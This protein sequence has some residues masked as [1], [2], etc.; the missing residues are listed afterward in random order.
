VA[1][2]GWLIAGDLTDVTHRQIVRWVAIEDLT[3][4]LA[5]EK[6]VFWEPL[7]S[8]SLRKLIRDEP[9]LVTQKSVFEIGTGS[10]LIALCCSRA[11]ARQVV[12]SD[13]NP[14]A[15][16]C[17]KDNARRMGELIDFRLVSSDNSAD[18]SAFSVDRPNERFDLIISNPPWEDGQP[19]DWSDYALYDPNF[20]LLR[21]IL[22]GCRDHLHPGGRVLLAYG[23]VD[24][25]HATMAL[26]EEFDLQALVLDERDPES[27][28]AVFLPGMLIGLIPKPAATTPLPGFEDY[29]PSAASAKSD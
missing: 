7:D 12:A 24:A 14:N 3:E 19:G 28:P 13:I 15:I 27:M 21:S 5:I 22:E 9:P 11:G 20:Q 6:S 10:G 29:F 16:H 1:F 17:A 4:E 18:T 2:A 23:C 26:A 25:I 8:E